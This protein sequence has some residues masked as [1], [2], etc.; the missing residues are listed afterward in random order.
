MKKKKGGIKSAL[1]LA[2]EKLDREGGESAVLT[3]KQKLSLQEIDRELAAKV[4]E[5]EILSRT[6]REAA[7]AAG[8]LDRLE[9]LEEQTRR[10]TARLRREAERKKKRVREERGS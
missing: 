5:I 7:R 1:E 8:N 2:M 3:E 6:G 9:E 10:E 4:A